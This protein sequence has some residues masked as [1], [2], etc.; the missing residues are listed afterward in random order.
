[1]PADSVSWGSAVGVLIALWLAGLAVV[2]RVH[3]RDLA[4]VRR[5]PVFRHPVLV[6]DSDDWGAGPLSQ[7]PALRALADV[8]AAHRDASGRTPVLNLALVLA[9]PDGPAIRA[10]RAYQRLGLDDARFA[11][12]VDALVAGRERGVFTL[13]LHGLEHY[14]PP[15]LMSSDDPAVAGWLCQDEPAATEQL[16]SHLQS[17]W[18]DTSRL[19]SAPLPQ[20]AVSVAAAQE[21]RAF[22]RIVGAPPAVV[23][24]PTFVWTRATEAAWARH[25]V[26]CVVTPGWRYTCRGADGL[27]GGDE[28]PI[29]N[30]DRDGDLV[31]LARTDYFEPPRRPRAAPAC[32]RTTATTSSAMPR[33]AGAASTNSTACAARR[34]GA[35]TVCAS[36]R[37]RN[38][39][40][41]CASATRSGWWPAGASG[42]RSSGGACTARAG[43]GSCW[44]SAAPRR[45][46]R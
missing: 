16:P 35:T 37:R 8:L 38:C 22:E 33:P 46:G 32:S 3:R 27:P 12:I 44:C 39:H 42:C 23:V 31:Y 29:V 7:A 25:G 26:R 4:R 28:G 34:C 5:E 10:G 20:P 30:G 36:C 45:S 24:P 1:M 41:S 6:L 11:P 14:W 17:R 15:T 40:A 2:V 18:V 21:V 43:C 19:P 13:Q 9:V